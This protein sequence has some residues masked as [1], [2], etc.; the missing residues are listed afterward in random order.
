MTGEPSRA[1]GAHLCAI[2]GSLNLYGMVILR[3][4]IQR[5]FMEVYVDI[6]GFEDYK[7]SN[8]GNVFSKYLNRNMKQKKYKDGYIRICLYRDG[9]SFHRYIHRLVAEHF[10]ENP[11]NFPEVDHIDCNRSNNIYTNLMWTTRKGNLE[12]C[13]KL[14]TH[15]CPPRKIYAIN[16]E[17][18][19]KILFESTREASRV[20]G[21]SNGGISDV[22]HNRRKQRNGYKFEYADV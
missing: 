18:K 12:R 8:Y 13:F 10:V 2:R 5:Y 3:L 21:I 22:L 7:I 16:I 11:N 15:R 14:K 4:I 19:E 17:T 1:W 20:L 6:K 9:K